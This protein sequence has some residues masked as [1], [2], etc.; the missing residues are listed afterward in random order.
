MSKHVGKTSGSVGI[1][2]DNTSRNIINRVQV[3]KTKLG[4]LEEKYTRKIM[5]YSQAL[6]SC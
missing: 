3:N 4:R 5:L 2:Q 6:V 1:Q